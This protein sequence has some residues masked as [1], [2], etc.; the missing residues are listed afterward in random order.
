MPEAPAY[1]VD[2]G[3]LFDMDDEEDLY[4][5][6]G[7]KNPKIATRGEDPSCIVQ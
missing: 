6:P 1:T 5:E 2:G 7:D 3:K 4:G